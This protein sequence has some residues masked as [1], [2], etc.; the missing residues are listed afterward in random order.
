MIRLTAV[1]S[2]T[3]FITAADIRDDANSTTITTKTLICFFSHSPSGKP[4]PPFKIVI[5]DEADSMTSS[6]Q[7]QP[8]PLSL[9]LSIPL[10]HMLT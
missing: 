8:L 3:V 10:S 9:S 7:V 2:L 5:L 6:A 4:C 1:N